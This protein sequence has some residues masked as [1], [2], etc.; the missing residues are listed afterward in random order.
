MDEKSTITLRYNEALYEPSL[1]LLKEGSG[2]RVRA[3]IAEMRNDEDD[4][5]DG[6]P[7]D[8]E[9]VLCRTEKGDYPAL[10]A[11]DFVS[12]ENNDSHYRAMS[13]LF[14]KIGDC[15]LAGN[16]FSTTN[17]LDGAYFA[18]YFDGERATTMSFS[19]WGSDWGSSYSDYDDEPF[20]DQVFLRGLYDLVRE[21]AETGESYV[22]VEQERCEGLSQET[23]IC[24]DAR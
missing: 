8:L 14:E 21:K 20:P 3:V 9:V 4:M 24:E 1:V 7:S 5:D 23:S 11:P 12:S 13:S 16:T 10:Y 19:G 18:A 17:Y 2:E 6:L 22:V 15:A